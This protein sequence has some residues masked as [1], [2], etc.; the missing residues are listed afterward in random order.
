MLLKI[1]YE[2]KILSDYDLCDV[3]L[4]CDDKQ[5]WTHKLIISFSKYTKTMIEV[6]DNSE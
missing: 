3:T 6:H 5:I 1:N 2:M 4:T